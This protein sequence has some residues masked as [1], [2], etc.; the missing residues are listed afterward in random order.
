MENIKE[1]NI[2]LPGDIADTISKNEIVNL[3]IQ[4]ALNKSEYYRSKCKLM[5]IKYSTNFT[6]FKSK[7]EHDTQES[8]SEWDDLILWEGYY[9]G[10]NEWRRKYEELKSCLK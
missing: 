5:E 10:Y 6:D 4:K 8:F 7:V 1:V 2:K 3:L 9:L